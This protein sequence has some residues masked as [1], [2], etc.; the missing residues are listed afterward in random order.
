MR[1]NFRFFRWIV[2]IHDW[3]SGRSLDYWSPSV[4]HLYL[5]R[6]CVVDVICLCCCWCLLIFLVRFNKQSRFCL[7]VSSRRTVSI[8]CCCCCCCWCSW[9]VGISWSDGNWSNRRFYDGARPI[10]ARRRVTFGRLKRWRR[11]DCWR[12]TLERINTVGRLETDPFDI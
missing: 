5:R 7:F 11:Q 12:C 10:L 8:C 3:C 9:F 4:I 2:I 1:S 6:I